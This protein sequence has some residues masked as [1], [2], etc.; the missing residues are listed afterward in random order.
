MYSL[1]K[2]HEIGPFLYNRTYDLGP[3]FAAV[4][5]SQ[6]LENE[7]LSV[8]CVACKCVN[9]G[10]IDDGMVILTIYAG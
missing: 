9:Y 2:I 5:S 7:Y 1:Q 6:A 8:A 3:F 10:E 4:F